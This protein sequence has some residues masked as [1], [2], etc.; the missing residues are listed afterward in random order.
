MV[1]RSDLTAAS[2]YSRKL[3]RAFSSN[4][5]LRRRGS[6]VPRP[7]NQSGCPHQSLGLSYA[8]I[9]LL[10]PRTGHSS[11]RPSTKASGPPAADASGTTVVNILGLSSAKV[12][13][14]RPPASA[15]TDALSS[16]PRTGRSGMTTGGG[17]ST[18]PTSAATGGS[19]SESA[20]APAGVDVGAD[21]KSGGLGVAA[22]SAA[23]PGVMAAP[24][25]GSS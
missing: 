12:A 20:T 22:A 1:D 7:Q 24:M 23:S 16:W 2:V 18:I 10:L 17:T 8:G 25:G 15:T 21:D 13:G 3:S 5:S 14:L 6:E 4:S 11:T 19:A 9:R